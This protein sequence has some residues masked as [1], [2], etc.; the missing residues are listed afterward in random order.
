MDILSVQLRTSYVCAQALQGLL[1][2]P[3]SNEAEVTPH[4]FR[5]FLLVGQ[6]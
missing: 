2:V 6:S 1:T 5:L 4:T 3:R